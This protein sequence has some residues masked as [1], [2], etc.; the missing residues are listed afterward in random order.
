MQLIK[1]LV[2]VALVVGLQFFF[3][4]SPCHAQ[5]AKTKPPRYKL[6]TIAPKGVGWA[7]H[8]ENIVLPVIREVVGDEFEIKVFWGGV[9]G[10]EEEV[11]RKMHGG[12][13]QGAGFSGQ[14]STLACPAMSVVELPFLFNNYDEV[15][16]IK[17][18]MTSTFEDLFRENG[19]FLFAWCDQDFDVIISR[20]K[21]FTRLEDFQGTPFMTWYGP[22]EEKLLTGLGATL[23]PLDVPEIAS[24]AQAGKFQAAIGPCVFIL[25]AQLHNVVRNINPCQIRYSPS[26][27]VLTN[28]AWNSVPQSMQKEFYTKRPDAINRFNSRVREDNARTLEALYKYGLQKDEFSRVE[29]K[30]LKMATRGLW[31]ELAG[32]LYSRAL[33]DEVLQHLEDYRSGRSTP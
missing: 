5:D 2:L 9:M 7:V 30:K 24:A 15:D 1:S 23:A 13:L 19:F 17:K 11:I 18:K 27:N 20:D 25:G 6:A 29:L 22:L 8:Y 31:D 16:Y 32:S 10:D 3:S 33:L 12:I 26:L 4:I 14:G 28:A 21:P